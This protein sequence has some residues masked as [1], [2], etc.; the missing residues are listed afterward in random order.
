MEALVLTFKLSIIYQERTLVKCV[1]FYICSYMSVVE[2]SEERSVQCMKEL[3]IFFNVFHFDD[4]VVVFSTRL[5]MSIA[6]ILGVI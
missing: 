5:K 2:Q 4:D 3:E 1:A 6:E